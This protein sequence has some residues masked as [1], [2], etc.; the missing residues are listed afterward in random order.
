MLRIKRSKSNAEPIADRLIPF[1]YGQ[2]G[3]F[4]RRV[5]RVP[6]I[7]PL[8]EA[9]LHPIEASRT[10]EALSVLNSLGSRPS[11]AFRDRR[12]KPHSL[13][14]YPFP[15]ILW[16]P[17]NLSRAHPCSQGTGLGR[18]MGQSHATACSSYHL[19]LTANNESSRRWRG[20]TGSRAGAT[21]RSPSLRFTGTC[22]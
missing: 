21:G 5:R 12:K 20:L 18:Q 8:I 1:H 4:K 19:V 17:W 14:C 9:D 6:F 16:R 11:P 22:G 13:R 15:L 10:S 7:R 2:L 3:V